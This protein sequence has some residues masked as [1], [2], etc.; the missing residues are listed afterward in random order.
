M[1]P[2]TSGMFAHQIRYRWGFSKGHSH[3]LTSLDEAQTVLEPLH[4]LLSS[5][6]NWSLD[7][8]TP[9]QPS[10]SLAGRTW[11]TVQGLKRSL[12]CTPHLR[13]DPG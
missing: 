13:S 12:L 6:D 4:L 8:S 11:E 10:T 3:T 9:S 2:Y 5:G 7:K 1:K